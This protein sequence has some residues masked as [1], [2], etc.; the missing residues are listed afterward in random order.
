[1]LPCDLFYPVGSLAVEPFLDGKI[2]RGRCGVVPMVITRGEP[3]LRHLAKFLLRSGY[4]T[5]HASIASRHD[6]VARPASLSDMLA[7][8]GFHAGN[9]FADDDAVLRAP[10]PYDCENGSWCFNDKTVIE[11]RSILLSNSLNF[12][13]QERSVP[14]RASFTTGLRFW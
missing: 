10:S 6:F 9:Y 1:M 3:N 8:K 5:L 2:G 14:H 13:H 12:P 4:P 7:F 11:V